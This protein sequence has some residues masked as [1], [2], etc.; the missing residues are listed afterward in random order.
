M[1]SAMM[2]AAMSVR[3]AGLFSLALAL[4]DV[5]VVNASAVAAG[6]G[7]GVS[8]AGAGALGVA[9][10]VALGVALVADLL[11]DAGFSLLATAF[12]FAGVSFTG[13]S[14]LTGGSF[15]LLAGASTGAATGSSAVLD[16]RRARAF[17]SATVGDSA[18]V[19]DS[20]AAAMTLPC[21]DFDAGSDPGIGIGWGGSTTGSTGST[22]SAGSEDSGS[23]AS[24][25]TTGGTAETRLRFFAGSSAVAADCESGDGRAGLYCWTF[26]RTAGL[27]GPAGEGE[28]MEVE[29]DAEDGRTG[30]PEVGAAAL[31]SDSCWPSPECL[32]LFFFFLACELDAVAETREMGDEG[33]ES[34]GSARLTRLAGRGVPAPG[35]L[36]IGVGATAEDGK[37]TGVEGPASKVFRWAGAGGGAGRI[38]M[39]AEYTRTVSF[40][41]FVATARTLMAW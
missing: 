16:L 3:N 37:R 25:P 34:A 29:E 33:G 30:V 39:A 32:L 13:V 4:A 18:G 31:A 21:A 5:G 28:E 36:R 14:V 17:F 7:V 8:G 11:A 20:A 2:P 23:G 1:I 15:S 38:P 40:V 9:L 10:E 22:V 35:V 6:V 24:V 26:G 27:D 41:D 12:S 19:D